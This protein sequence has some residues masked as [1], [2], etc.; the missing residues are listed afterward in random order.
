MLIFEIHMGFQPLVLFVAHFARDNR[1]IN[2]ICCFTATP[3]HWFL[4]LDHT[5]V[6]FI[7][8]RLSLLILF[9]IFYCLL[10]EHNTQWSGVTR[11]SLETY[12]IRRPHMLEPSEIN[13]D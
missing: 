4:L 12:W 2:N 1:L 10:L 6:A 9:I 5:G 8:R 11:K 13:K 7:E 3:C